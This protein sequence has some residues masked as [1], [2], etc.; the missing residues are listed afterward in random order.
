MIGFSAVVLAGGQP[1][2]A[3]VGKKLSFDLF[4][5]NDGNR[6][7]GGGPFCL[8]KGRFQDPD[9]NPNSRVM[10]Q[11]IK[12]GPDAVP[13]LVEMLA[14]QKRKRGSEN[15]ICFWGPVSRGE[16]AFLVLTELFL[17][18][19]WSRTT[20]PGADWSMVGGSPDSASFVRFREYIEKNGSEPLQLKWRTLWSEY[21][22]KVYWDEKERCFMLKPEFRSELKN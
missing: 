1:V 13:V 19:T 18:S 14:D 16:L 21:K 22:D 6:A 3:K 5:L 10:E 12:A 20:V 17:D 11:I 15:I 7:H 4:R 8:S 2:A 9:Y